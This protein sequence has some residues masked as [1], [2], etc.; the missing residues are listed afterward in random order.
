MLLA[1]GLAV[2]WQTKRDERATD[3]VILTGDP[4]PIKEDGQ[5]LT[6]SPYRANTLSPLTA[7]KSTNYLEHILAREEAQARN[8]D[9]AVVLNERGEVISATMANLFWVTGD[10]VL[11]TPALTTGALAGTARARV[12]ELAHEMGVP[13][14]EGVYDFS[15]LGEASEIFLTSAR[16]GMAFVTTFDFRRYTI[17]VGSIA[18]RLHEAFRQLTL[19]AG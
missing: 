10:G 16:L 15:Q 4:Y 17:H 9:E 2:P 13:H 7:V 18:L 14:V 5:A 11:H 6:L 12:I 19:R 3:F 1:R 8:F